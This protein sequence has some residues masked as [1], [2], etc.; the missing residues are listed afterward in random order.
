MRALLKKTLARAALLAVVATVSPFI[1]GAP[2]A[3]AATNNGTATITPTT[4]TSATNF[5]LGLGANP[6]CP[7]D[8]AGGNYRL[9][10]FMIP[11]SADIDSTLRF[12]ANGPT[13]VGS[14][15][16]QPLF[17]ATTNPYVNELTD[18]ALTPGGPG[19]ISGLP[20]F[21]WGA[22]F[23]PGDVP[24]GS[25]KI[26]IACTLG[27]A[28]PT[29]LQSYWSKVI[30]VTPTGVGLG[31][32]AQFDWA[33]AVVAPAPVLTSPLGVG[34]GNLTAAFTQ[35]GTP[36]PP[37]TGY[38]ATATP[39]G[40]GTPVTA[41]GTIS[42]ITITGLTNGTSYDVT[43]RATNAVGDSP[44]SN[45]VAGTPTAPAPTYGVDAEIR[46]S[47]QPT[48]VGDGVYN[49]TG[50]GQARATNVRRGQTGQFV[51]RVRNEASV[52]DSI[53]IKGPG[54]S[55]GFTV[56]Y[57]NGPTN[58]TAQVVAGTFTYNGMAPTAAR[59]LTVKVTV[60]PNAPLNTTRNVLVRATSVGDTAEKDAVKAS[61]KAVR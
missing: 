29:Q 57:S 7:G 31:G 43:V 11:A 14:E 18:Q 40:G 12:N 48:Y 10:S 25:Y 6:G 51:V 49:L 26:G 53:R 1:G 37:V 59:S 38:T 56:R 24:A 33:S 44:E 50:A 27:A 32:P 23:D 8:S 35:P 5:T 36:E 42:P 28:G 19:G 22:V 4:G 13:A 9:Q 45:V 60:T 47:T 41:T 20:Q 30:T 61:V 54:N 3:I 55:P 52:T 58:V 39:T 17:D 16:R 46:R 21:N 2:A 15:F 34:D